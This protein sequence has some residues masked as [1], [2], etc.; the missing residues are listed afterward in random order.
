M[1]K[2]ARN[3]NRHTEQQ[4][5]CTRLKAEERRLHRYVCALGIVAVL[6]TLFT[7]AIQVFTIYSINNAPQTEDAAAILSRAVPMGILAVALMSGGTLAAAILL[8]LRKPMLSVFGGVT[9]LIGIAFLAAFIA[10][11]AECFPYREIITGTT[12]RTQG[13]D[14]T[15][16]FW[17]HGTAFFPSLFL[18]AG[19]GI[20]FA[21]RKKRELIEVMTPS[22]HGDSTLALDN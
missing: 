7:M 3:R 10:A 6:L 12:V 18:L 2:G 1:G 19:Q 14:F 5:A 21:A 9:L 8:F 11:L 15:K 16:L 13:L 20:A 4:E 22:A 17:R